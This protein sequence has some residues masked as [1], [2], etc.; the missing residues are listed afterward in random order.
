M[1]GI[2][3]SASKPHCC[4]RLSKPILEILTIYRK[5]ILGKQLSLSNMRSQIASCT[6]ISNIF[7]KIKY[8]G[9]PK[10]SNCSRKFYQKAA[11]MNFLGKH[12]CDNLLFHKVSG[13][14]AKERFLH[15]CF[16]V[17]FT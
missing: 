3:L 1:E 17:S 9:W 10:L 13:K 4:F 16:P 15:K 5:N 11:L 12:L 14:Q 8:D 2:L 6:K 7:Y